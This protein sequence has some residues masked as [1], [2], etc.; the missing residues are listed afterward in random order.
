MLVIYDD[1]DLPL[2]TIRFRNGGGTGGH[3]GI[4]S[5]IYQLGSENFNRLRIG[6]ATEDKMRPSEK[7]VLSPFSKEHNKEIGLVI[8]KSIDGLEYLLDNGMTETMNKFN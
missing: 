8:S 5:I 2:G 6:I 4:E 3:K 1:I 7:Y